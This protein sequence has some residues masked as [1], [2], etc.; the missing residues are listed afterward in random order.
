MKIMVLAPNCYI[1]ESHNTRK[2][3]GLDYVITQITDSLAVEN[4]VYIVTTHFYSKSLIKNQSNIMYN[5][6]RSVIKGFKINEF[7]NYMKIIKVSKGKQ[8]IKNIMLYLMINSVINKIN[9]VKPDIIHIHGI[10]FSSMCY[11]IAA[12]KTKVPFVFTLHGLLSFSTDN[13]IDEYTKTIEKI[14]LEKS[15]L[16]NQQISLVSSGIKNKILKRLNCQMSSSL[17]VI[18]NATDI[19]VNIT[20]NVNIMEKYKL[21]PGKKIMI[22]VGSICNNKNQKQL[23]RACSMLNDEVKNNLYV[24]LIGTD[25]TNGE[26]DN[27][28]EKSHLSYMIKNCGFIDKDTLVSYYKVADYN[29]VLSKEEGFGLSIIEAMS[30]GIPT[31]MFQDLDIMKDVY[32]PNIILPMDKR[33]DNVVKEGI[34]KMISKK[35]DKENIIKSSKKFSHLSLSKEYLTLYQEAINLESYLDVNDINEIL[36]IEGLI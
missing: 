7:R 30:F 33:S 14:F 16:K 3:T 24:L 11:S 35:W 28:I 34:E 31:L 8:K 26:V 9:E 22:C 27:F 25:R 32:H 21:T 36:Q 15:L 4:E 10:G 1:R 17:K 2:W 12:I 29:V 13:D 18:L 23:I 19:S 20:P 5:S 6:I